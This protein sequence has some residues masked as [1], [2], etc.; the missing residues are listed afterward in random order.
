MCASSDSSP[1]SRED[2]AARTRDERVSRARRLATAP[3]ETRA[4]IIVDI[5]TRD[6]ATKNTV[7]SRESH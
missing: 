3:R 5:T 7:F 1:T 6:I 2:S 4:V